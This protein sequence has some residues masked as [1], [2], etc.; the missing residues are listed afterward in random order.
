VT[1]AIVLDTN[2]LAISEGLNENASEEC[3]DACRRLAIRIQEGKA[4]LIVDDADEIIVEYLRVLQ[5]KKTSGVGVKLARI[6]RQRKY[7]PDVCRRVPITALDD[8]PGSYSEVP[9]ALRDFDNDDQKFLAVAKADSAS[10]QIYAGLDEEWWCRSAELA[11]A[12]FDIQF[13][14]SEDL[15]DIEC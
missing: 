7:S 4:L 5:A 8:P 12:G 14:C 11:A 15:L 9:E 10:P 2:V 1:P 6:L 3:V 13:P